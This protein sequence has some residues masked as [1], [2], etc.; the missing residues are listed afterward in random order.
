[1]VQEFEGVV[2]VSPNP[3]IIDHLENDG[4]HLNKT[5]YGLFAE[6]LWGVYMEMRAKNGDVKENEIEQ[7]P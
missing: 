5:G 2:Y 1:M 4:V 7:I 3:K 6:G